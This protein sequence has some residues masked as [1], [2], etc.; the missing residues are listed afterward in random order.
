[1]KA[2]RRGSTA[3]AWTEVSTPE[4]TMK[5]PS[6]DSEKVRSARKIVQVFKVP[7]F[8]TTIAECSNAVPESQGK[9]CH[10][11]PASMAS[12]HS[13]SPPCCCTTVEFPGREADSWG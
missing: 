2:P 6:S 8:S 3:K 7:R 4:R 13:L 1:M 10:T 9:R 5:V 11:T 12:V